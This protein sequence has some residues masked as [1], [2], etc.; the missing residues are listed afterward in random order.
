[1]NFSPCFT[2]GDLKCLQ[3]Q[4]EEAYTAEIHSSIGLHSKVFSSH[5]L[6]I[7]HSSL[8]FSYT[9][10]ELSKSIAY[11][12]Q[13]NNSFPCFFVSRYREHPRAITI[14]N[15]VLHVCIWTSV[16]IICFDFANCWS[17]LS[18]FRNIQLIMFWGARK[19]N[20]TVWMNIL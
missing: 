19:T 6:L 9:H 11:L 15:C 14:Y 13:G 1:M 7:Q 17:N 18:W 12:L 10:R 4:C 2:C 3:K 8:Y 16:C 5:Y 20:T